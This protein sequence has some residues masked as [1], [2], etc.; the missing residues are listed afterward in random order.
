MF[1]YRIGH[2]SLAMCTAIISYIADRS[3]YILFIHVLYRLSI[4]ILLT[5]RYNVI[6]HIIG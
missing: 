5:G 4:V 3:S 6:T 2:W 1:N